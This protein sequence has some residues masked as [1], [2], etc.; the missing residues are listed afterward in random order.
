LIKLI[1]EREVLQ[2]AISNDIQSSSPL[3]SAGGREEEEEEEKK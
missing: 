3:S 2:E 1:V